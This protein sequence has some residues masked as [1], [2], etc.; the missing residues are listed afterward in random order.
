M[1]SLFGYESAIISER[2]RWWY[3]PIV[4]SKPQKAVPALRQLV[5]VYPRPRI[6]ITTQPP[7]RNSCRTGTSFRCAMCVQ[8]QKI[9][10][11]QPKRNNQKH[12][13]TEKSPKSP[14]S[15]FPLNYPVVSIRF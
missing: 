7:V 14:K 3:P 9:K 2:W 4:F 11:H 5:W 15:I 12:I 6:R 8:R 1:Y 10:N 13:S